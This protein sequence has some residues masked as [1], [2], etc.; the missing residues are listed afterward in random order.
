[1][2]RPVYPCMVVVFEGH[3]VVSNS[4]PGVFLMVKCLDTLST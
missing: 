3:T 4:V 1:M 2:E